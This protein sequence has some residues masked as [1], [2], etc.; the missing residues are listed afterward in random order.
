MSICVCVENNSMWLDRVKYMADSIVIMC[1][2]S[3]WDRMERVKRKKGFGGC[4]TERSEREKERKGKF[5]RVINA[6]FP[7]IDSISVVIINCRRCRRCPRCRRLGA[8]Y[9]QMNLYV[10]AQRIRAQNTK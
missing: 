7:Q 5:N 9:F 10:H 6:E 2:A 1:I 4:T 8:Y 3:K